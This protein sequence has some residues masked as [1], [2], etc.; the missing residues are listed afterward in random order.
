[1]SNTTMTQEQVLAIQAQMEALKAENA[2]LK[3][4]KARG[5]SFKVSEKGALSIY[6]LGRFPI[7]MYL[8][9]WQ[10]FRASIPAVDAFVAANLDKFK[11][12]PQVATSQV[13]DKIEAPASAKAE[14]VDQLVDAS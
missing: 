7:T 4:S 13:E 2:A 3:A 6:G 10:S 9:Q 14:L 8:S 11:T 12:K 5:L 1:M